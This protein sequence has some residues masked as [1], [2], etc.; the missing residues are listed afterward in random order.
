MSYGDKNLFIYCSIS[1]SW[2]FF[3]LVY[4]SLVDSSFLWPYNFPPF[5]PSFLLKL[6]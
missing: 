6:N 1:C 2:I 5:L 3:C 4:D